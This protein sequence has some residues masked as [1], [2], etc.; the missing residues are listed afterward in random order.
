VGVALVLTSPS[1]QRAGQAPKT[2]VGAALSPQ[3]VTVGW[4]F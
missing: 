1:A 4:S 3:G 2:K